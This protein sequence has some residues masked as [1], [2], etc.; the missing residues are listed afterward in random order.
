MSFPT[1]GDW[2]VSNRQYVKSAL[3]P[4]PPETVLAIAEELD[5][6][7]ARGQA[8]SAVPPRAWQG[9]NKFR[10][11]ISHI[12]KDKD[13]ATRLRDCLVA[14]A[15]SGFVS[16][17]DIDP[18]TEWQREIERGLHAMDAFLAIHTAGFK[19]SFW[20]QQEVGFAF[21]RGAKIISFKMGEDPTGFISIKQA[22][23]RQNRRAEDIAKEIDG[24]LSADPMTATKLQAA[25]KANSVTVPFD[26]DIPF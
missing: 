7:I 16:H 12:S 17:E 13:K 11:F 19:E 26:D 4:A 6:E 1:G 23:P 14:H 10:L 15:I 25:K 22:L 24:L 21:G 9:T 8:A 18:D 3:Y 2:D 20:A 5:I